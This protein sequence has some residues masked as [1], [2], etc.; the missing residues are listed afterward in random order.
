M[1]VKEK[2]IND[3]DNIIIKITDG[4]KC[5]H[6]AICM[7]PDVYNKEH[8][9]IYSNSDNF[10]YNPIKLINSSL[11]SNNYEDEFG[12]NT[13]PEIHSLYIEPIFDCEEVYIGSMFFMNSSSQSSF[14]IDTVSKNNIEVCRYICENIMLYNQ[15]N[16]YKQMENQNLFLA[17][18]S[19]EIRTPLNGIIG[20]NQ[21]LLQT[22]LSKL[23][24]E[25]IKNMNQCSIQLMQIINDILDFSKLTSGKMS[26]NV[27]C[28]SLD[29][30]VETLQN[31]FS[32]RLSEKRQQLHIII[33][34][35][36]PRFI[37]MD[38]N[39]LIQICINLI[40]NASKFSDINQDISIN[41]QTDGKENLSISV[42]DNGVGISK[43]N[44]D[45]LFNV[46]TQLKNPT[47]TTGSGLGLA[48]VKKL[49]SLL[50][51]TICIQSD[52]G[53]GSEFV[54]TCK[55]KQYEELED[56]TNHLSNI[57]G[58]NVLIVDDTPDNRILLSELIYSFNMNPIVCATGIE[59]LSIVLTKRWNIDIALIDICMPHISG[60][61]LAKQIK[62]EDPLLPLVALSSLDSFI[63]TS[64][65]EYKL[66]KPIN[67][68]Q[69]LNCLARLLKKDT[70][71]LKNEP[72]N[73]IKN[74]HLIRV[75]IA[76]DVKYNTDIL[77][78]MLNNLNIVHIDI[79]SNGYECIEQI[80]SVYDTASM[81]NV[82]IL[83]LR[84]P[85]LDGFGVM[86]EIFKKQWVIDNIIVTTASIMDID[87]S[88]CVEFGVKNFIT[89]PI[90]FNTLT[91]IL[92]NVT[93]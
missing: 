12:I 41:I 50:D 81:Y 85:E 28:F 3:I 61:E 78:N 53:I 82:L 93:C 64:D 75:L 48:I 45:K 8:V 49:V 35:N 68:A 34:K 76:E 22:E 9:T 54:F 21:L 91:N 44:I 65:F 38:K 18:M 30:I 42:K 20:Y 67:K 19:H 57:V 89:K 27:E 69:L 77:I 4:L 32:T 5:S 84:M 88:R 15:K 47:N 83:D 17:N 62:D 79:S 72:V 66:D 55:Y 33:N 13:S 59:A 31:S 23:Q 24:K 37:L 36:V 63:T 74:P 14:N 92:S 70:T 16:Y 1:E 60:S 7:Y 58:K 10:V 87:R 73:I 71:I 56:E 43:Q 90:N 6:Y 40:T 46:F 11:I 86:S 39:K 2:H 52:I 29:E 80:N 51:G 25:Y 26:I